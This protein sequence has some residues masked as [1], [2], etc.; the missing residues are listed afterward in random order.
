MRK[1]PF[2]FLLLLAAGAAFAQQAP[3]Q[4][5]PGQQ[6]PEQQAP[7]QQVSTSDDPDAAESTKS[8]VPLDEI[9]GYVWVYNAV[10]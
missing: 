8:K 5:A 2:A 7:E 3:E 10:K 1:T 6:T 4:Q 9:S